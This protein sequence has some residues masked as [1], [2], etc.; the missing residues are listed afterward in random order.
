MKF[1]T[2]IALFIFISL[3]ILS[4]PSHSVTKADSKVYASAIETGTHFITHLR[5]IGEIPGLSVAVGIHGKLVWEHGFGFRDLENNIAVSEQTRFRLGSVSKIITA[6]AAARLFERGV[7]DIDAPIEKYLP[8]IP[9]AYK[10]ITTRQLAGHLAGVR[11]YKP[12]DTGFETQHYDS[13]KD[14]LKLFTGDPLAHGTRFKIPLFHFRVC[15]A[16]C[17]C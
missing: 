9:D 17:C 10:K 3:Q 2:R 4:L 14:A 5:E 12:T 16:V 1:K 11:H 15:I 8:T 13:L 6:A 7:L